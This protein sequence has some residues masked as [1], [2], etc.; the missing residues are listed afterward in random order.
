M[1]T[2]EPDFK[3]KNLADYSVEDLDVL[4]SAVIIAGM[5]ASSDKKVTLDVWQY[6]IKDAMKERAKQK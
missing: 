6:R 1:K 3:V 2:L 5:Y 4:F